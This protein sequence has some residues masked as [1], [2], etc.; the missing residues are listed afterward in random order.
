MVRAV[1]PTEADAEKSPSACSI[2][3]FEARH[4]YQPTYAD[5]VPI[6]AS[7]EPQVAHPLPCIIHCNITMVAIRR[8]LYA[9]G[10]AL[11]V[12]RGMLVRGERLSRSHASEVGCSARSCEPGGQALIEIEG[13]L[14]CARHGGADAGSRDPDENR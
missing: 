5:A 2:R 4:S 12:F 9:S 8:R 7:M 11:V 6:D 1:V 10:C 14:W 13:R 3:R